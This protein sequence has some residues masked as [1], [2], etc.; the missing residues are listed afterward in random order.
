[1]KLELVKNIVPEVIK[2]AKNNVKPCGWYFAQPFFG[3]EFESLINWDKV[4]QDNVFGFV[5]RTPFCGHYWSD[6]V[7]EYKV[8]FYNNEAIC[9]YH[10][11]ADRSDPQYYWDTETRFKEIACFL[12]ANYPTEDSRT[13]S[14]EML[15]EEIGEKCS[16]SQYQHYVTIDDEIYAHIKSPEIGGLYSKTIRI[17]EDVGEEEAKDIGFVTSK[18]WR[19]KDS[20]SWC[21]DICSIV[22]DKGESFEHYFGFDKKVKNE[23]NIFWLEKVEI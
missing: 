7:H 19:K 14:S 3:Y 18:T 13:F 22:T 15:T 9:L 4:E 16:D 6:E 5:E 23:K 20:S 8:L 2:W 17:L 11:I 21:N 1:M 10:K 12:L